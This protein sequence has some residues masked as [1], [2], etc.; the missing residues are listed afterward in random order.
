[1]SKLR[2]YCELIRLPN[3]FTAAADILA[4]YWLVAGE[5]I[6]SWRLAALLLSACSLYGAGIIINDLRDLETDRRD[7]PS[8]PLPSGRILVRNAVLLAVALCLLGVG[9]A[10]IAGGTALEHLVSRQ[11][12]AMLVALVLLAAILLYDLLLKETILGPLNMGLCRALNL[13][14]GMTI[15]YVP[16]NPDFD[17]LR[18]VILLIFAMWLYVMSLTYFGRDEAGMPRRRRL[19]LGF[20]GCVLALWMLGS[21]SVLASG[22][23]NFTIIL[24]LVLFIHM[25][26]VGLRTIR[27]P[28]PFMVQYAMKTLILG[29]VAFDAV[30]ASAS[31]GWAAAVVILSLLVPTM[32]IGRRIYST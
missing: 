32:V 9:S 16:D 14:L 28:A 6:F 26:R 4:G 1:M 21:V 13:M 29:I 2:S 11:N 20:L 15:S 24:W 3:L 17:A 5:L 25:V 10:T 8:R 18:P 12:R 31:A 7:R 30:I 27:N 22:M 19:I 23:N